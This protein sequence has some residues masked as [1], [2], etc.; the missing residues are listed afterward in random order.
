MKNLSW[1]AVIGSLVLVGAGCGESL[2]RSTSVPQVPPA[3]VVAPTP[4]PEPS[5]APV[6]TPTPS[7]SP[8]PATNPTTPSPATPS[9]TF[10]TPPVTPVAL[11][12]AV[13]ITNSAFVSNALIVKTGSVVTWTN[14]DSVE[15]SVV[16]DTGIFW[17]PKLAKGGTYSFTF[18]KPGIYTYHCGEHTSMKGKI[19][20]ED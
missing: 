11:Q 16:A 14:N 3:P 18:D 8:A 17:S 9:P 1:I 19:Q 12:R 4:T 13:E 15:H 6:V 20:V 7:P 10:V 5:P 2:P